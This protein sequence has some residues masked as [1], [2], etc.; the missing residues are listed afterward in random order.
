MNVD[1]LIVKLVRKIGLKNDAGYG[2]FEIYAQGY[3][4]HYNI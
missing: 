2:L 4:I 3:G 1:E